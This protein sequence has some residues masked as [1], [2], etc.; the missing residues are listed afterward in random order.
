M[1]EQLNISTKAIDL[2]IIKLYTSSV[3]KNRLTQIIYKVCVERFSRE[4][5]TMMALVVP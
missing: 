3:I 5:K 2:Y 1:K 4:Y